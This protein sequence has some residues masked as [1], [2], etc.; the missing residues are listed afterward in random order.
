MAGA[1]AQFSIY[2]INLE[3]I[4]SSFAIKSEKNSDAYY[5]EIINAIINS[6][7]SIVKKK[8]Y[9]SNIANFFFVDPIY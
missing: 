1:E 3:A 8:P 2:K 9:S 4:E 5:D 7:A 6:I